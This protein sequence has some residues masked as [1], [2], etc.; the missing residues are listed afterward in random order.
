MPMTITPQT[1]P[2]QRICGRLRGPLGASRYARVMA[3][4]LS[5]TSRPGVGA[6][7]CVLVAHRATIPTTSSGMQADTT[8]ST[9]EQDAEEQQEAAAALPSPAMRIARPNT[10]VATAKAAVR[11]YPADPTTPARARP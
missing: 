8:V 7:S 5:V 1:T 2:A 4:S 10:N 9:G 3:F 11:P 6:V